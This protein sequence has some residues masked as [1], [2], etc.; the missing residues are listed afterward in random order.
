[1]RFNE[2]LQ[3]LLWIYLQYTD[4]LK[5]VEDICS[6]GVSELTNT[7]KDGHSS[8]YPTLSRQTFLVY[9]RVLMDRLEKY[10][11]NIPVGKK[12]DSLQVQAE[13]LVQWNLAVRN[14]HI[15]VNLIKVFDTRPM[16]SICLKYGRLFMETFL[17]V[18]MPLL[19][20]SFKKHKDIV[21]NLLKILQMCTRQL[22]HMC[23]HSKIHRDAGLTTHVPLLK[24]TLEMFVYRVKAMLTLNHCQEAFWLGN[25]KN[26]DLQG[27]EILSQTAQ[28][29]ETEEEESQLPAEEPEAGE[30]QR[31]AR[32]KRR[33]QINVCRKRRSQMNA[34]LYVQSMRRIP[35][36]CP[37]CTVQM[38]CFFTA[39][40][41]SRRFML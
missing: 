17:K 11:R 22:H 28:E 30:V 10:V 24:K 14:F 21:Q 9:F 40:N 1:M 26:R 16:L 5:A 33:S 27:E 23:G 7:T 4:V 35:A 6:V 31:R 34:R 39:A 15:L 18:G 8:T 19:D 20:C 13:H 2:N 12:S 25:L 37:F 41:H 3:S 32:R 36:R 29:S 38:F